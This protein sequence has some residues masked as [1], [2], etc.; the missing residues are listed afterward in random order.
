MKSGHTQTPIQ[1]PTARSECSAVVKDWLV[2]A[3]GFNVCKY[4]SCVEVM[5]IY[6]RQWHTGPPTPVPWRRMKTVLHGW[7]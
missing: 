4:L 1:M 3:G 6:S 5:N 2:V 7:K